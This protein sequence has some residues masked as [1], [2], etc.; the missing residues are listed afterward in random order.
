[1]NKKILSITFLMFVVLS[2]LAFAARPTGFRKT[3]VRAIGAGNAGIANDRYNS[4]FIFNPSLLKYKLTEHFELINSNIGISNNYKSL[5]DFLDNNKT[6]L[7][8]FST[9]S[10]SA[11]TNLINNFNK[12]GNHSERISNSFMILFTRKDFAH[13]LFVESSFAMDA[14]NGNATTST[15]PGVRTRSQV[16]YLFVNGKSH[17]LFYDLTI[18]YNIKTFLRQYSAKVQTASS[19]Y[20][21]PFDKGFTKFHYK[22]GVSGDLGLTYRP[23]QVMREKLL[24]SAACEDV[25]GIY[26]SKKIKENL[27]AGFGWK[28]SGKITVLGEYNDILNN[29]KKVDGSKVKPVNHVRT[30]M[31]YYGKWHNVRVGMLNKQLTVGFGLHIFWFDIDYAFSNSD[32][33]SV[34]SKNSPVHFFELRT[35]F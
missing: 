16:D 18:G 24:L 26:D 5:V 30:G 6:N 10:N 29:Y 4:A 22:P 14:I 15:A 25:L 3:D 34:N 19:F 35:T 7:T 21:S 13:A 23:G 32:I 33:N 8:N 9:L 2:N 31:E 17:R 28:V 11:Q 27:K 20:S 1:M 12:H